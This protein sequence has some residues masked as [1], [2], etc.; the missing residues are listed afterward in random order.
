VTDSATLT[1]CLDYV[2][3]IMQWVD[4]KEHLL[5]MGKVFL[6]TLFLGE[7]R[8]MAQEEKVNKCALK[9]TES[10]ISSLLGRVPYNTQIVTSLTVLA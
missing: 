8:S 10:K 4:G 9:L 5:A 6:C 2:V 3:Q 7:A 1:K